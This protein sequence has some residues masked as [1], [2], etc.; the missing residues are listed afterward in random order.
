MN[1]ATE[2]GVASF[3]LSQKIQ[4]FE[5]IRKLF[6]K[7]KFKIGEYF[8]MSTVSCGQNNPFSSRIRIFHLYLFEKRK[9][10]L[11]VSIDFILTPFY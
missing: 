1:Y 7:L 5:V 11:I 8:A 2:N 4:Y 6:V 10:T 9:I 3:F